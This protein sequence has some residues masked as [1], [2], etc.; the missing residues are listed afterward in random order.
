MVDKRRINNNVINTVNFGLAVLFMEDSIS[1]PKKV[2]IKIKD[3]SR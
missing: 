1:K 3:L 2:T